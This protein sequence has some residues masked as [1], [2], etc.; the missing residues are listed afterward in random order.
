MSGFGLGEGRDEPARVAATIVYERA[1]QAGGLIAGSLS[2]LF[3][4]L[5][6]FSIGIFFVPL[7]FLCSIVGLVRGV[8]A[9][10]GSGIGTS[11][12]GAVLTLVGAVVSPT[13]WALLAGSAFLGYS[14]IS[15]HG[16]AARSTLSHTPAN[17]APIRAA[18]FTPDADSRRGRSETVVPN[19][20]AE[21]SARGALTPAPLSEPPRALQLETRSDAVQTPLTSPSSTPPSSQRSLLPSAEH[22]PGT[23]K[24]D[25]RGLSPGDPIDVVTARL[26]AMGFSCSWNLERTYFDCDNRRSM[27]GSKEWQQFRLFAAAN[28]LTSVE[29]NF[30]TGQNFS[31]VV[32]EISEEFGAAPKPRKYFSNEMYW[33]L[34]DGSQLEYIQLSDG[35][36]LRLYN[37]RITARL[38]AM[39]DDVRRSS[40]PAPRF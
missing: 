35:A 30:K 3:G 13:V 22:Q 36:T 10:S 4:L 37:R 29:L 38:R 20:H 8:L 9:S 26:R 14:T 7:A 32:A 15:T 5:G 17:A 12:L 18:V 33:T 23:F 40:Y 21:S 1:S 34:S 28:A 25:I 19:A 16:G 27:L 6:I 11:L 2:I 24:R 39:E 31:A